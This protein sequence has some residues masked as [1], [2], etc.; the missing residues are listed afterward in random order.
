MGG[1]FAFVLGAVLSAKLI[2]ISVGGAYD[3]STWIF[4]VL[5]FLAGFSERF[6]RNLLNVVESTLG[7]ARGPAP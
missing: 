6:S 3:L 2:N 7:G 5:G 4:V 1:I